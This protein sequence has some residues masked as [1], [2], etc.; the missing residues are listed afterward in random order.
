M[1]GAIC[2]DVIGSVYEWRPPRG[3]WE[4]FPLFEVRTRFTDDTVM[5][6]AVADAL[7][8]WNGN[9]NFREMLIDSMHAYGNTY[10]RAGYGKKFASWIR[11]RNRQAY[12]SFGNGSAMRVSPVGWFAESLDEAEELACASA[13]I[14]HNH[15][16]GV[17][18]AQS[19]AGS[20]FL[21]RQGKSKNEIRDY[22]ATKYGYDLLRTLNDI[23][24]SYFFDVTCQ[25]S[26]PEAIIAFLE[27]S[28]YEEAIRKAIWLG[29]DADT[30]AAISGSIAEA[31]YGNVPPHIAA[32]VIN[33]LDDQLFEKYQEWQQFMQERASRKI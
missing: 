32:G 2:G 23:K 4:E 21:A 6:I 22:V 29:G 30:Q 7:M 13:D 20:I 25:G 10:P 8:R 12:N 14:T 18:G 9:G 19:V 24:P 5:T 26:V 33:H 17:K 28:N 11:G 31:F 15:P 1:F 27:S 3:G 16:E